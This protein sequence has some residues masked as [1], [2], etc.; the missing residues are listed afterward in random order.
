MLANPRFL[1]FLHQD[2]LR[3][4]AGARLKSTVRE[5][6]EVRD[7]S[8]SDRASCLLVGPSLI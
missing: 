3:I 5:V 8:W 6:W 1:P 4:L 2:E 7:I